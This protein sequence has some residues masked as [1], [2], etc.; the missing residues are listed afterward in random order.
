MNDIHKKFEIKPKEISNGYPITWNHMM[1]HFQLNYINYNRMNISM[2]LFA[3]H[4]YTN[5]MIKRFN[6]N[7]SHKIVLL[8]QLEYI[9][10]QLM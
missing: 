1:L 4:E 9:T 5:Y 7:P 8:K 3:V 2:R 10:T 6:L